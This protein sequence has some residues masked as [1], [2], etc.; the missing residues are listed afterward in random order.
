MPE[1]QQPKLDELL[2]ASQALMTFDVMKAILKNYGKQILPGSGG[3]LGEPGC[4]WHG[5]SNRNS[6]HTLEEAAIPFS[7]TLAMLEDC[8]TA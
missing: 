5:P 8:Q 7:I 6:H 4:A 1:D 2:A 3:K